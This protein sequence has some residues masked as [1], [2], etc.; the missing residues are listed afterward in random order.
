MT[1]SVMQDKQGPIWP[2]GQI[3]VTSPG[4]P[5][6]IMSLVDSTNR[7]AP[8]TVN[9]SA[10]GVPGAE[11][12]NRAQQILFQAFKGSPAVNNT[13]NIYII[14]KGGTGT[15]NRSD[16]GAIVVIL[17]PGQTFSLGS[18]ALNRSVFNLYEY[19]IDADNANDCA[20]VTAIIQ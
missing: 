7:D 5:V 1:N 10:T 11:Y 16:T 8:E 9:P 3:V 15:L 14:K 20:Q 13:G 17:A 6:N 2:L 18:A 4:T 19:F 12:T